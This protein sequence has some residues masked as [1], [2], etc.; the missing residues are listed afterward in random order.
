MNVVYMLNGSVGDFLM[1]L[2]L[3]KEI[4]KQDPRYNLYIST[5][6]RREEFQGLASG[7]PVRI[8][9]QR[10]FPFIFS[11]NYVI[12][13]P[14]IG[15]NPWHVKLL[16][17]IL[18][19]RGSVIDFKKE[20]NTRLLFIEILYKAL[21]YF[22]LKETIPD[23]LL[24]PEKTEVSYKKPYIVFHPFGS[25]KGRSI[26]GS[27]QKEVINI[28]NDRFPD[29]DVL[30]SGSRDDTGVE[31]GVSIVGKHSLIEMASIIKGSDLFIG[32]DTGITHLASV[33]GKKSLVIASV[34]SESYWLPFYNPNA[35]IVY[36]VKGDGS[37]IHEGY[38]Y[39]ESKR[40]G[41][42]RYLD[43]VDVSVIKK[44]ISRL[45]A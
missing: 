32:V 3:M 23:C 29:H 44:A 16:A 34:G 30:V 17:R 18:A 7:Y 12:L 22:G 4:H 20:F 42:H 21:P 33:L 26:L 13:T 11:K 24:N 41:R 15:K 27:K 5:P 39:L 37:G 9:G 36:T 19:L 14:T 10:F 45:Y 31:G 25:N 43:N 1:A 40:N 38:K 35:K 2:L 28:L 6:R 8:I